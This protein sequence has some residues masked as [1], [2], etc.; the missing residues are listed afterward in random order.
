MKNAQEKS[1]KAKKLKTTTA[2]KIKSQTL[3]KRTKLTAEQLKRVR[4]S[5]GRGVAASYTED[6]S[7]S[8]ELVRRL[9]LARKKAKK[10]CLYSDQLGRRIY[11]A[12]K[13]L[14]KKQLSEEEKDRAAYLTFN[15]KEALPFFRGFD[16]PSDKTA[17]YNKHHNLN[18]LISEL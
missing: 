2:K 7:L 12:D 6:G 15:K 16:E 14:I 8:L 3:T 1:G 9:N 11:V 5:A 17:Y 18:F 10:F 13:E 4:G